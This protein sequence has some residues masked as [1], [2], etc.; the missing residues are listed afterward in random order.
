MINV[1]RVTQPQASESKRSMKHFV[2][3]EISVKETSI[4]IVD[5]TDRICGEMKVAWY[6]DGLADAPNNPS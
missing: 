3:L 5:E 1:A 6:P 2:G 4:C